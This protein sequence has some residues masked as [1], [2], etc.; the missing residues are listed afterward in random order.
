[1]CHWAIL[2][3]GHLEAEGWQENEFCFGQTDNACITYIYRLSG[4]NCRLKTIIWGQKH[5][6]IDEKD[7]VNK[8]HENEMKDEGLHAERIKIQY[9][10]QKCKEAN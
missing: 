9:E 10:R 3:Q 5:Y 4:I 1:M 7:I 8:C 6:F 2:S